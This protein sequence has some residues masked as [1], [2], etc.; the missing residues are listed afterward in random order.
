MRNV[1][2]LKSLLSDYTGTLYYDW[3][4]NEFEIKYTY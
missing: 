4:D 1:S 3:F 2:L